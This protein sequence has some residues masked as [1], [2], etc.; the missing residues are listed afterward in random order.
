MHGWVDN[1]RPEYSSLILANSEGEQEDNMLHAYELPLLDIH[2]DLIVLSACETGFGRLERGEG[3]TSIG[4]G[5]MYAG[6]GSLVMTLWSINDQASAILMTYF[7][8]HLSQNLPKHQ[9]L[10]LAKLDFIERA[11]S[12]S[13]H[14]FFWAGFVLVGDESP[15]QLSHKYS[16]AIFIAY[17]TGG[18]MVFAG[19]TYYYF[20]RRKKKKQAA[21]YTA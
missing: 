14:P 15:L 11:D 10:R 16:K 7:Y 4:R 19:S 8:Q 12:I 5:F 2:A 6:A 13:A 3:V 9:A 20:R 18:I 1:N 21:K 17:T